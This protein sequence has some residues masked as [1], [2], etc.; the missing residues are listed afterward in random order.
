MVERALVE[1]T[2]GEIG[3]KGA[4]LM[5][6]R[7]ALKIGAALQAEAVV[8]GSVTPALQGGRLIVVKDTPPR[9]TSKKNKTDEPVNI[10]AL[11]VSVKMLRVDTGEILW[12]GHASSNA[13]SAESSLRFAARQIVKKLKTKL[14]S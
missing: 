9:R 4:E 2:I 5:D 11:D 6:E 7:A 1:K 8:I 10:P 3:L 12:I 14:S 13:T